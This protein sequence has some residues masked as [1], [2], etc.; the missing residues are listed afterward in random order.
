MKRRRTVQ[1]LPDYTRRKPLAGGRWGYYFTPP[2]WAL[3]PKEGDDRGPCPVGCE[4]LGTDYA[5]AVA[6]VESV[7]LPLFDSWRTR[8]A[9]DLVPDR[10]RKGTLD[11][12]F[13]EYRTTSKFKNLGRKMRKLH[14]DGFALVADY[15]LKDGRRLGA[16]ALPDIEPGVVDQLYQKLLPKR[17]AE[18]AP[19]PL[20]DADGK[21]KR[22]A[23][24]EPLLL[25]RRTTIN[26]AMKSCRRAWN[27]T[28]RLHRS[29]VPAANPFARMG[30]V[31]SA[32][33][34]VAATYGD[35]LAAVAQADAMGFP[36]LGTALMLTWEWLQREEHIFTALKLAH[37][38]PKDHPDEVLIVHPKNGEAVWIPLFA[39]KEGKRVALFPELMAR[40]DAAKLDRV[41]TG[42]FFVRDW[43]DQK[44]GVPLAWATAGGDLR[45]MS[46]KVKAILQGAELDPHITFT[47]FRHGGLT[48]LGDNDLTDAQIRALSRHKSAKVLTRYVKRTERQIIDG[49]FKRRAGRQA[50]SDPGIPPNSSSSRRA[51]ND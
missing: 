24:G 51:K 7:L 50:A 19:V 18:G 45:H 16:V 48:E 49:T 35:L 17:D 15:L 3:G 40:M 41:G 5:A 26:H 4:A 30:L 1:P 37:Y 12:L 10:P 38:R 11:W 23:D 14:N 25:E 44:A 39:I 47:S 33:T 28:M 20:L 6:R 31:A 36:S 32:G 8:G 9:I 34:V 2:T 46:R 29:V 42:P 22:D 21:P 43:I 27:V 13:A